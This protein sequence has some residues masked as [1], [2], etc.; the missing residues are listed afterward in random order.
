MKTF[1][2]FCFASIMIQA[3]ELLTTAHQSLHIY[4][5]KPSEKIQLKRKMH[6]LHKIDEVEAEKIARSNC[7]DENIQMK[8]V[9][10]KTYLL[11]DVYSKTCNFYIN[12]L[13][14]KIINK[15]SFWSGK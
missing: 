8:L 15:K 13:D 12:A 10:K 11:Y 5:K 14:G 1:I 9:H 6:A 7:A 4:N 3:E 2:L